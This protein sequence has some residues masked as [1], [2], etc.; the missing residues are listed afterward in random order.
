VELPSV[1]RYEAGD[2]L[3]QYLED[4]K[5]KKIMQEK[6]LLV[7]LLCH[8]MINLYIIKECKK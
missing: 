7:R 6:A 1:I 4:V 5:K 2:K 3:E 8:L